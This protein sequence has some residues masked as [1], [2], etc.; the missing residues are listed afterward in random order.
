MATTN[1][2]NQKNT[3]TKP[4]KKPASKSAGASVKP[5]QTKTVKANP[6]TTKTTRV[7]R[8]TAAKA[9]AKTKNRF[10]EAIFG[11]AMIVMAI[12][13]VACALFYA[14][15]GCGKDNNV[16]IKNDNGN[17]IVA[18][19]VDMPEYGM[20][21]AI[22]TMF[23]KLDA[24]EIRKQYPD[25]AEMV[26]VAYQNDDASAV[27]SIRQ[28]PDDKFSNDNVKLFVDTFKAMLAPATKDIHTEVKE[29]DG[30]NLGLVKFTT[31]DAK[32]H[33]NHHYYAFF[34]K[35]DK[36]TLVTFEC[37]DAARGDWEKV[38]DAVIDSIRFKTE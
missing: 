12:A 11:L 3:K 24:E 1:K 30:Y 19:Y 18:E 8:S 6:K 32:Q 4:S 22:P 7:S 10:F 25:V 15:C 33:Y 14:F 35:D 2:T 37:T 34:S 29:I 16:I 31:T 21:I 13:I 27:I 17:H 26:K 9:P 23:K 5:K 38:G 20:S 28:N 36:A